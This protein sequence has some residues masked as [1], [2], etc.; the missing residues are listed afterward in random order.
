MHLDR[1]WRV[2]VT[3][4][5]EGGQ[6]IDIGRHDGP[7]FYEQ[8]AE[9][10]DIEGAG[11]RREHKPDCCGPAGWPTIGL[12]KAEKALRREPTPGT[13]IYAKGPDL[14]GLCGIREIRSRNQISSATGI[15][16]PV[17]A[18]RGRRPSPLDD[19]GAGRA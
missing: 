18:V 7:Q 5:D 1:N 11:Q 15:R 3:F 9:Q 12:T 13:G 19:S 6:I 4:D 17:S 16:T 10:Y 8:L 14:Q 2:I